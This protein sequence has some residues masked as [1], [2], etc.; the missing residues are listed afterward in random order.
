MGQTR[1]SGRHSRSFRI[2]RM[3]RVEFK[4][5]ATDLLPVNVMCGGLQSISRTGRSSWGRSSRGLTKLEPSWCC[6]EGGGGPWRNWPGCDCL[7]IDQDAHVCLADLGDFQVS[8]TGSQR[9]SW[10]SVP[11]S[12]RWRSF[13]W[14]WWGSRRTA[15]SRSRGR[16]HGCRRTSGRFTSSSPYRFGISSARACSA[17]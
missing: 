17:F 13:P 3:S 11:R 5:T 2:H 8:F 6:G 16:G 4:T 10:R 9:R 1:Q 7:D 15:T 12:V 14:C